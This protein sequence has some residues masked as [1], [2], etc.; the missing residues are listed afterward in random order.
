MGTTWM[1]VLELPSKAD[2]VVDFAWEPKGSRFAVLH[3]EGPKP[4]FSLYAM[5]DMKTSAK[6]VQ[7]VGSN[8]QQNANCIH[9]SPQVRSPVS[10]DFFGVFHKEVKAHIALFGDCAM[11]R[12]ISTVC[13]ASLGGDLLLSNAAAE[14][15][16][17]DLTTHNACRKPYFMGARQVPGPRTLYCSM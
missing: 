13:E 7:L 16:F 8:P 2:K 12:G 3:S 15:Y 9:W 4:T 10:G 6:G 1:Q 17:R 5:K 14:N 11:R